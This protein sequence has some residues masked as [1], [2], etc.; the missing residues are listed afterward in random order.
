M[1]VLSGIGQIIK[2]FEETERNIETNAWM[3]PKKI[4]DSWVLMIHLTDAIDTGAY[5]R[6]VKWHPQGTESEMRQF[7]VDN[8]ENPDVEKYAGFVEG[9]TR[10]MEAR[11]PAQRGI[12]REDFVPTIADWIERGFQKS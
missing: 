7:I 4:Q 9:G 6:S 8:A 12:E 2:A 11:F 5:L 3:I 1:K 10:Y